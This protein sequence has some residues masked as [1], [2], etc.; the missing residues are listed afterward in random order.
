MSPSTGPFDT[1]CLFVARSPP[2][3]WPSPLDLRLRLRLGM[4]L[5]ALVALALVALRLVAAVAA[6][7]PPFE[8]GEKRE[9]LIAVGQLLANSGAAVKAAT[10]VPL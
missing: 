10:W 8:G 2:L 6:A 5:G 1:M 9:G 3:E 4:S 7:P